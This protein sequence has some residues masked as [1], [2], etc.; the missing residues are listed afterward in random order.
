VSW[1]AAQFEILDVAPGGDT[2]LAQGKTAFAS[3]ASADAHFLVNLRG[4]VLWRLDGP[5]QRERFSGM[6][7]YSVSGEGQ[8]LAGGVLSSGGAGLFRL[9]RTGHRWI[10]V[11]PLTRGPHG[12]VTAAWLDNGRILFD[13]QGSVLSRQLAT[14]AETPRAAGRLVSVSPHPRWAVVSGREHAQ[15]PRDGRLSGMLPR[16]RARPRPAARDLVARLPLRL[17]L[18]RQPVHGAASQPGP[19]S[20]GVS[21]WRWLRFEALSALRHVAPNPATRP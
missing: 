20:S 19:A 3:P 15:P 5:L 10:P 6:S 12:A 4:E 14:G 21:G 13:D 2:L 9:D 17:G 11:R 16:H 1:L 18:G 7:S 8:V